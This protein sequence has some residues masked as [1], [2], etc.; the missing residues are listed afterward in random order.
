[1][2]DIRSD[3]KTYGQKWVDIHELS[4]S[5]KKECDIIPR[6][7]SIKILI[8]S[9][10]C[11]KCHDHA[12]E[13]LKAHDIKSSY[14]IKDKKGRLVGVFIYFVEFHNAVNIRLKKDY[15]EPE[16]AISMYYPEEDDDDL[17]CTKTCGN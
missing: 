1:M 4:A 9:I 12:H 15:L 10:K 16:T 2:T 7:D 17:F 5:I 13:Y 8:D 6:V 14:K 11:K 3:P